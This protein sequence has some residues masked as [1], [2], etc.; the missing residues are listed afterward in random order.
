MNEEQYEPGR[1]V[2]RVSLDSE[3][4]G[5][6]LNP[7]LDIISG[8]GK[9][10]PSNGKEMDHGQQDK[11]PTKRYREREFAPTRESASREP[12]DRP[13]GHR[14]QVRRGVV[15]TF[16]PR[17]SK[18]RHARHLRNDASSTSTSSE[19][20]SNSLR[21]GKTTRNHR[22]RY[23]SRN[24]PSSP[25][26]RSS[27]DTDAS[28]DRNHRNNGSSS[29]DNSEHH[30]RRSQGRYAYTPDRRGPSRKKA[31]WS[32]KENGGGESGGST[33][34]WFAKGMQPSQFPANTERHQRRHFWLQWMREFEANIEL[35][36]EA[37]PH[38]K[39]TYL[40]AT[41]GPEMRQVI[42]QNQMRRPPMSKTQSRL[43]EFQLLIRRLDD[44][45]ESLSDKGTNLRI[46]H[47]M[48]QRTGETVGAFHTRLMVQAEICDLDFDDEAVRL[49][50]IEGLADAAA[51]TEAFTHD[52]SLNKVLRMV[53]RREVRQAEGPA[54]FESAE[55]KAKEADEAAAVHEKK[56]PAWHNRSRGRAQAGNEERQ[57]RQ[58]GPSNSRPPTQPSNR[59]R[60]Q[61]QEG[62]ASNYQ[63][64]GEQRSNDVKGSTSKKCRNC[65][66]QNCSGSKQTCPANKMACFKCNILG[67][68]AAMCRGNA[69][70]NATTEQ[71]KVRPIDED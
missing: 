17:R 24:R 26:G 5:E 71:K 53:N 1:W 16:E 43:N 61:R 41:I 60:Y 34:R 22:R 57:S 33:G 51:R 66:F 11:S 15:P 64:R 67:H 32:S 54:H 18:Q 47:T 62:I 25:T 65:I 52:Y 6:A 12:W 37:P 8:N 38:I 21:K 19:D 44:H 35:K 40:Y 48:K 36:G 23:V 69:A 3:P 59:E 4:D 45:F 30:H 56:E 39:A 27:S 20:D 29:D 46:L 63:G 2:R 58:P 28:N 50:F 13:R 9:E 10:M 68:M 7:E 42:D 55:I 70:V 31:R 49:V 14:R